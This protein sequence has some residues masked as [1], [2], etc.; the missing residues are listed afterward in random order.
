MRTLVASWT[1][2]SASAWA[3]IFLK[4]NSGTYN[5]Q[6]VIVDAKK[7]TPGE[8]PKRDFV[9][10]TETM[11]GI[12]IQRDV[13]DVFA[14]LGYWPSFNSPYF[15]EIFNAAGYPEKIAEAGPIGSWYSYYNSSRY[16]IFARDAPNIETFEQFKYVM[17]RNDYERDPLSNGDPAQQIMSRYDLRPENLSWGKRRSHG[18]IDLKATSVL[19]AFAFLGFDAI[20]GP[21]HANHPPFQFESGPFAHL[22]HDGLP[23]V[24]NFSWT[25]FA[26]REY[27][28]CGVAKKKADCI[29][30]SACGWCIY[31]QKCVL[32]FTKGPA[33]GVKCEAGWVVK[34]DTQSWATAVIA[35]VCVVSVVFMIFI[36][37]YHFWYRSKVQ[38]GAYEGV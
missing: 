35:S 20:A 21:E 7:F 24:S 23:L 10:I 30:I 31:D 38:P 19:R 5:N 17:Y 36:Y 29:E 18:G 25:T 22:N 27:D 9:W 3:D 32:G 15:E 4:Q 37:G 34:K 28:R 12:A 13:T 11:P 6:Y 14:R 8:V 2:D 26:G 1:A 16:K 33:L